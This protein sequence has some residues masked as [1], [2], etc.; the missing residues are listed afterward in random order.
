MTDGRALPETNPNSSAPLPKTEQ[1]E[2][3]SDEGSESEE[4][5]VQIR[6]LG[7]KRARGAGREGDPGR[8]FVGIHNNLMVG[9][10]GVLAV[11]VFLASCERALEESNKTL[12]VGVE[13][14]IV[15]LEGVLAHMA[16]EDAE[17]AQHTRSTKLAE[18]LMGKPIEQS[19]TE[20]GIQDTIDAYMFKEYCTVAAATVR[21]DLD[22][23]TRVAIMECIAPGEAANSH[24]TA[25]SCKRAAG[26]IRGGFTATMK[27]SDRDR[28]WVE[29]QWKKTMTFFVTTELPKIMDVCRKERYGVSQ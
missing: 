9:F 27:V 23:Y 15:K 7:P 16:R 5:P 11:V 10:L 1:R 19:L 3:E 24:T 26:F 18:A 12:M 17:Q 2:E 21:A 8:W 28:A 13:E 20:Q 29:S 6:S 25:L 14:R 22:P 4:D